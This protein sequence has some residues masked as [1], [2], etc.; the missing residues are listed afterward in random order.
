MW[1]RIGEDW[2]LNSQ[3]CGSKIVQ[4]PWLNMEKVSLPDINLSRYNHNINYSIKY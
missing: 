3:P 1:P 2:E 4:P